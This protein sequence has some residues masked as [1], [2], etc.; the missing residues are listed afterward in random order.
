MNYMDMTSLMETLDDIAKSGKHNLLEFPQ[1]LDGESPSEQRYDKT[2]VSTRS[3]A[4]EYERIGTTQVGSSDVEFWLQKNGK[5][6]VRGTINGTNSLTGEEGYLLV[7]LVMFKIGSM[8]SKNLTKYVNEWK[9]KQVHYVQTSREFRGT[10]IA[11][12]VYSLMV[13]LGYV[14]VSDKQ[15]FEAGIQ[16]WKKM[17]R[18]AG[19]SDYVVNILDVSDSKL[20]FVMGD[21]GNPLEYDSNDIDDA[22][23]WSSDEAAKNILLVMRQRT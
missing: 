8:N 4:R 2:Y 19:L 22:K 16:L 15:Q 10:G 21:A 17:A 3:M 13:K 11:A 6:S 7:F 5:A 9:L 18:V 14:V 1:K 12:Y 20:G 23:I